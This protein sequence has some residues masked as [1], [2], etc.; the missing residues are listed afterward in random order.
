VVTYAAA[1]SGVV[2]ARKRATCVV[3]ASTAQAREVVVATLVDAFTGD[4][5]EAAVGALPTVT[6]YPVSVVV[7]ALPRSSSAAIVR[8]PL[9]SIE[10]V[11]STCVP[12]VCTQEKDETLAVVLGSTVTFAAVTPEGSVAWIVVS[13]IAEVEA[14]VGAVI[15][16]V[17]GTVSGAAAEAVE[18]AVMDEVAE[19]FPAAS[20]AR[21]AK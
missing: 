16:S 18:V 8:S 7:V 12:D 14:V 10:R 2:V 13:V 21:T 1:E 20:Y 9:A 19:V 15:V 17:G 3:L 4:G 6:V 11:Q 5:E